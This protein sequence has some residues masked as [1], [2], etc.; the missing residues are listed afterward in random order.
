M[1]RHPHH[2]LISYE[3]ENDEAVT[4]RCLDVTKTSELA[5]KSVQKLSGGELQRIIIARALAQE[6]RILL[7]DE[8]TAHLDISHQL[9]IM[10]LMKKLN[11]EEKLT[12]IGVYHDL[13]LAARYCRR[14]LILHKGKIIADGRLEDV[15]TTRNLSRVFNIN[16]VIRR[17]P[18]TANIYI[19]PLTPMDLENIM[20]KKSRSMIVN[21]KKGMKIHMICGAG[22]GS[23]LMRN[24]YEYGFELTAGVLNVLDQDHKT[25]SEL[26]L[27][28]VSEA[29][30]S[31]IS[32][33]SHE[34][35]IK[36][37][38][39]SNVV[40][41][42]DV[43]FGTANQKNL[44]AVVE[45]IEIKKQ[46]IFYDPAGI[47]NIKNRDFTDGTGTKIYKKLLKK[48][49]FASSLTQILNRLNQPNSTSR[50]YTQ[51]KIHK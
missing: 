35:N 40:I 4:N 18:I 47:N 39:E 6:P 42:T 28:I 24:L 31:P 30:F 36:M 26:K 14:L 1:G 21:E 29:S 22:T 38:K 17:N 34:R 11:E 19:D 16:A 13:N 9:E 2:K 48:A 25:A 32:K 51:R 20:D 27:P 5:E 46:V 15:L 10:D 49:L 41:V 37:I 44:E 12:V 33:K 45:S 23:D 43:P 3:S 7:L 50:M 8:P